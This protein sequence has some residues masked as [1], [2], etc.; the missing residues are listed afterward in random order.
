MKLDSGLGWEVLD[1]GQMGNG[2]IYAVRLWLAKLDS[3]LLPIAL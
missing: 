3:L 1:Y 2:N